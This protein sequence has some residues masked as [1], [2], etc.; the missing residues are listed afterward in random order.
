MLAEPIFQFT[1]EL[2]AGVSSVVGGSCGNATNGS[3]GSG[4]I[5]PPLRASLK[6]P[7]KLELK[8][9]LN[10]Q[11]TE[12]RSPLNPLAAT[13]V[14]MHLHSTTQVNTTISSNTHSHDRNNNFLNNP[15]QSNK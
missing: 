9:N 3:G 7:S 5:I 12:S 13:T 8:I 14:S 1:E 4:R 2:S 10:E 6:R 11:Q 15:K